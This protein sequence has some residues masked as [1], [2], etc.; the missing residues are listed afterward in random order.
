M[1]IANGSAPTGL[2]VERFS[3]ML[4]RRVKTPLI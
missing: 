2:E 1:R 4:E 3:A